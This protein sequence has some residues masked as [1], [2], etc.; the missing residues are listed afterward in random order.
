MYI[1]LY[2]YKYIIYTHAYPPPA[3]RWK[4]GNLHACDT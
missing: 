4:I 3:I 1:C 2:I